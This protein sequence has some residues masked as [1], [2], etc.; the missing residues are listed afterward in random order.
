MN[1][2]FFNK[3][4]DLAKK[5]YKENEIPV[6]CVIVKDNKIIAYGYNKKESKN[7][8]T[9]HAEIIAIKKACLKLGDWRLDDCVMYVTLKPCLMCIG[10]IIESRIKT[11]YYGTKVNTEQM[12]DDDKISN[13]VDMIDL[14]SKEAARI[15]SDFFKN[16]RK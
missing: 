13:V 2:K 5:A 15:M 3:A 6:G 16:R 7:D 8:C 9:M 4:V 1:N 10:A 12:Y 14:D 11:V